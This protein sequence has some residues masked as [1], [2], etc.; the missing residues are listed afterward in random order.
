MEEEDGVHA[1]DAKSH[2]KY[3]TDDVITMGIVVAK[4]EEEEEDEAE[5]EIEEEELEDGIQSV[6]NLSSTTTGAETVDAIDLR[7]QQRKKP[8]KPLY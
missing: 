6:D 7:K 4:N 5:E 2:A 3:E 1:A 8:E